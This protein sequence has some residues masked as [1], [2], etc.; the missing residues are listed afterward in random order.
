MK[1]LVDLDDLWCEDQ[2]AELIVPL[3]NDYG[4]S[5]RV[6]AYTIPNK[7]G[8]VHEV[9][10]KYPW[11]TFGIH[12]YEHTFAEC[13]SW[14]DELAEELIRQALAMGYDPVFKPPNWVCD[15]DTEIACERLKVLLHHHENY[16]P[17]TQGLWCYPGPVKLRSTAPEHRNLHTHLQKNPV[18]DWI[19]DCAAFKESWVFET[20]LTPQDAAV[21]LV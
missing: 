9:K 15:V 2:I 17:Q 12:G 14:T 10:K 19:R 6:T 20:Y 3:R 11:I 18:T 7:M 8:P 4:E 16:I 5:F 13:R 21:Q 1:A